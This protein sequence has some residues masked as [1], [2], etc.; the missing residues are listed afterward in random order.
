MPPRLASNTVIEMTFKIGPRL[1]LHDAAWTA[2]DRTLSPQPA[3][4]ARLKRFDEGAER[5]G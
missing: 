3:R 5:R 4:L 2:A 1:P